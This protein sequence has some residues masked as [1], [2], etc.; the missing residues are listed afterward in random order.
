MRDIKSGISFEATETIPSAPSA[1]SGKV[2]ASSPESTQKFAG[3]SRKISMIC[4]RFPDASLTATMFSQSRASRSTVCA[5]MFDEV[6]PG[7]L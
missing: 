7:T 4:D 6:R 2:T 1:I 5:A 3:R